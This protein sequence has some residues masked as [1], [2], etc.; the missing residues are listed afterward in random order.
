MATTHP[1][2]AYLTRAMDA[3]RLSI[4]DLERQ[5]GINN[6]LIS[7]WRLGRTVPSME[8]L[9]L[10]APALHVPPMDLFVRAGHVMP[11]EAGLTSMPDPPE[12]HPLTAEEVIRADPYLSDDKKDAF[13]ALLNTLRD[14]Y[15][16]GG[17][18]PE[19]KQ[20]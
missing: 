15:A 8:N 3:A 1:F 9:R 18:E 20:A 13:I 2:G 11:E 16:Q 10:L 17:T 6:S 5:T 19:S 4:A 12:P 14:E 7:K